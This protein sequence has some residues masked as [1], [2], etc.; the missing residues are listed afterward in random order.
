M[1]VTRASGIVGGPL[2]ALPMRKQKRAVFEAARSENALYVRI[3]GLGSM[4]NASTLDVFASHAMDDGVSSFVF[5]FKACTGV[6]S[7]FMG[8]ILAI[9]N[10]LREDDHEGGI[11]LINVDDHALKQLSSVGVDAFVTVKE[12]RTRLPSRLRLTEVSVIEASDRERLKLMVRAHKELVASDA[13]NKA[14][15]GAFLEAIVSELG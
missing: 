2:E 11:V 5:D 9:S 12:G 14:K 15:F 10:R 3:C 6:D 7:T 1:R 13:R 4:T 8:L